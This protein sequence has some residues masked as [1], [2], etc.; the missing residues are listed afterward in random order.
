[1]RNEMYEEQWCLAKSVRHTYDA[2]SGPL[3]LKNDKRSLKVAPRASFC[4]V[5]C[6]SN[7]AAK[8]GGKNNIRLYFFFE[9]YFVIGIK[10]TFVY[11]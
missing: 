5:E 9:K 2:S 4:T 6:Y 8:M 11:R 7:A 3:A 10:Q 1:M